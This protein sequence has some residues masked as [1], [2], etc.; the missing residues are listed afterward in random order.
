MIFFDI[1][2]TLFD[3]DRAETLGALDF[4]HKYT[5]ELAYTV[6]EFADIW[7][8]LSKKYFEKYLKKELTF[9][10]QRRKRMEELFA[11][12]FTDEIADEKFSEYLYFYTQRWAI[13]ADVINCLA[14]L[15]ESGYS[16]GIITNGD[17]QQQTEKLKKLGIK[18]YFD[19]HIFASSK[20]GFSKPHAKIFEAACKRAGCQ[21]ENCYY[22]GDNL[23]IDAI[24]SMKAGLKGIW[25]NRK[26]KKTSQDVITIHT[27]DQIKEILA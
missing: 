10:E 22:I 27:L 11:K 1:D 21:K 7:S 3:H 14:F 20:M 9:Q 17:N 25:L 5:K 16:L 13:Y 12:N 24:G 2:G 4:Y 15:K 23:E 26:H 18:E 6:D 8:N 19:H